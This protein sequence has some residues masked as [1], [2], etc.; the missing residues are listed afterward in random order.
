MLLSRPY[1]TK[2]NDSNYADQMHVF[3]IERKVQYNMNGMNSMNFLYM[4]KSE[5]ASTE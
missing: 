2:S 1:E 4:Q 3:M 5:M